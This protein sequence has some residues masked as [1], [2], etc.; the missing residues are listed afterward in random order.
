LY[1][2]PADMHTPSHKIQEDI[3][4]PKVLTAK[5]VPGKV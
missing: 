1:F 2:H 3:E 5:Q 4:F